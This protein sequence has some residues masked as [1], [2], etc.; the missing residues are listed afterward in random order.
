MMDLFVQ[1]RRFYPNSRYGLA[2]NN[3][4]DL[5]ACGRVEHRYRLVLIEA[6]K[7][8]VSVNGT[9]LPVLPDTLLVLDDR[10]QLKVDRI[11]GLKARGL[12]VNPKVINSDFTPEMIHAEQ[13]VFI[14][15]ASR[16][17][18][19]IIRPFRL[20]PQAPC[21]YVVQEVVKLRFHTLL[22]IM[23]REA[24]EQ[25]TELWPCLMRRA[26]IDLMYLVYGVA[27][28][29]T[30]VESLLVASDPRHDRMAQLMQLI[31]AQYAEKLSIEGLAKACNTNR[32]SLTAR[33]R[34]EFGM[35]I[36]EYILKIRLQVAASL[37]QGTDL[38]VA[39][40][41]D[42]TGFADQSHFGRMFKRFHGQSPLECRHRQQVKT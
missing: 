36:M 35:S 26:L 42:K 6:G 29:G 11:D 2:I 8:T 34:A 1:G 18:F 5:L 40:I 32:T 25:E 28:G 41:A 7:G 31:H 33:F 13:P 24:Q 21:M 20:R 22:D 39:E 30:V 15:S 27:Q 17:D 4:E 37:L 3:D 38:S 16:Q 9:V 19:F 14:N 12:Y 10:D 23:N